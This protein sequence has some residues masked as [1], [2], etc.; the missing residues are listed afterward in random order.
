LKE[1]AFVDGATG[2]KA[3]RK[4]TFPLLLVAMA[5]V[6]I[7]AFAFN[8]NNYNLIRLLTDGGPPI[9]GSIAGETDILISYTYS[10]AFEGAG[11]D[12][13]LAT[14]ISTIIFILVAGISAFGFR[15]T[16]TFEEV[17]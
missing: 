6:L 14:A 13:G 7:S 8:F 12:F 16:R 11:Q 2:F 15:Y 4:V 5:P 3:F 1:A 9:P 17:N 10:V